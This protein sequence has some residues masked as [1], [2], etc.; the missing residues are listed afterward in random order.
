[1]ANDL[2]TKRLQIID[3]LNEELN[4]VK[5]QYEEALENDPEYQEIQELEARLK[6]E[7]KERK[8][9]LLAKQS[10]QSLSTRVKDKR[11][12][13]KENKEALSLDLVDHYKESGETEIEDHKGDTKRMKFSVKLVS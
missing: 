10:Y 5:E 11:Q 9:R 1:M 7:I 3:D 12:D 8:A 13:I 6:E 2:I 4:V